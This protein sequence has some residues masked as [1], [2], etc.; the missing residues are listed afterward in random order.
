[1]HHGHTSWILGLVVLAGSVRKRA[2]QTSSL[3][4]AYPHNHAANRRQS[5]RDPRNSKP[6]LTER[7]AGSERAAAS[8]S[9]EAHSVLIAT[10]GG[11]WIGVEAS[12]GLWRFA[13]VRVLL[14]M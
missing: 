6:R 5:D 10:E 1:M 14:R 4:T 9:W 2:R 11:C 3:L 12:C 8:V 7:T 13:W